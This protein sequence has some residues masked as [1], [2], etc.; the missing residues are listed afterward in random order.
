MSAGKPTTFVCPVC[1]G[2]DAGYCERCSHCVRHY[3]QCKAIPGR[4]RTPQAIPRKFYSKSELWNE[5]DRP[6]EA[7]EAAKEIADHLSNFK[8]G[9]RKVLFYLRIVRLNE[10]EP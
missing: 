4:V 5:P 10:R 2:V 3:C 7:S 8:D 6:C 1:Q 9:Q